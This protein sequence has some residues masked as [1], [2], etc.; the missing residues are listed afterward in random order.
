VTTRAGL[1]RTFDVAIIGGG[2]NGTGAA[3][4]C[5]MRGLRTILLEKNDFSSGTSWGSSGMIH[6][7]LRYL[8]YDRGTTRITCEDSGFVRRIASHLI[9]RI[10]FLHPVFKGDRYGLE[11]MEIV[12][13][14]YDTFGALKGAKKHTRLTRDQALALEPGLSP[15]IVGAVTWDEWGIDVPRL[16][17]ANALSARE[18][19][20]EVM[21]HAEVTGLL[22]DAQG[23]VTGVRVKDRANGEV[24]AVEAKITLN[25]AGPWVPRICRMADVDV[26]LRLGKGI[27]V[28]YD[29][30]IS[31]IAITSEAI[32]GRGIFITPH[33][34]VSLIGTTDDDYYGD[35]DDLQG[36]Q[37]EVE[38][39]IQGIERVFPG[40]RSYRR[41]RVTAALRP[42]LHAW[43][44]YEDAL[45]RRYE[46]FDH[47]ARDG[48]R[49]LVTLAGGKLAAYRLMAQDAT[50]VV[51][52]R[53]GVSARCRTHTE[54]LPGAEAPVDPSDL[55]RRARVGVFT[56]KTLTNRHGARAERILSLLEENPRWAEEVCTC[57]QVTEAEVRYAARH[58]M[59][60]TLSDLWFRSRVGMGPCHGMGCVLRASQVLAEE[61]GFST[62]RA[63]EEV[64]RSLKI[65]WRDKLPVADGVELAQEELVRAAFIG[66]ACYGAF[67]KNEGR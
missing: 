9:F 37:D 63:H 32:D 26:K 11:M 23:N 30:R 38:Y 15:G 12:M 17:V 61:R 50:D 43:G 58:E 55:A 53:L 20:A 59:A 3:R 49:G 41:T 57:E 39:L 47:E 2:V 4:D 42:T 16:C 56:A 22:R 25:C 62:E 5:A 34:N 28:V 51:A 14:A 13:K 44:K 6:G 8:G 27:H 19:G 18:Y 65:R 46:V 52:R 60:S 54:P 29:R 67:R 24:L 21:N 45:S 7:G 64:L 33:E 35:L 36:T 66:T 40:I 1:E 48:V 31:N 10:P